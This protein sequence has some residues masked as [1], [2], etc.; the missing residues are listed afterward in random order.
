MSGLAIWSTD[1]FA[2]C[3]VL[4]IPVI[5]RSWTGQSPLLPKRP[6][7]AVEMDMSLRNQ[8]VRLRRNYFR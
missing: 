8:R 5:L 4:M 3:D 7:R 1:T 6:R 2:T